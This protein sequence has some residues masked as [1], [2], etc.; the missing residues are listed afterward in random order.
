ML[1]IWAAS[2][3][4][5][6][7]LIEY[8]V[9]WSIVRSV[10]GVVCYNLVCPAPFPG[11]YWALYHPAM[12]VLNNQP[13]KWKMMIFHQLFISLTTYLIGIPYRSIQII[14]NRCKVFFSRTYGCIRSCCVLF[15]TTQTKLMIITLEQHFFAS[16]WYTLILVPTLCHHYARGHKYNSCNNIHVLYTL[17][18]HVRSWFQG[19]CTLL[20][21]MWRLTEVKK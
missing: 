17:R 5:V 12:P 20:A 15:T 14:H 3:G 10:W 7:P 21:K 18:Q 13:F 11:I 9:V 4:L 2:A 16:T 6:W 8:G 19:G 1:A